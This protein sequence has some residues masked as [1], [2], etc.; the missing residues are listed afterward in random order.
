MKRI[1]PQLVS[2]S[3][4]LGS[5]LIASPALA[6][7][8]G[9]DPVYKKSMTGKPTVGLRIRDIACMEGSKILTVV[10]AG[11]PVNIV[12]E[13]DGWYKV[14]WNGHV[15]WMGAS[16]MSVTNGSAATAEKKA[17]T[18]E[19]VTL[20]KSLLGIAEKDFSL[21]QKKN[22]AL[23]DRLK[24]KVLLRVQ[25]GGETWYVE[26]DGTLSQVKMIKKGEFKRLK[27]AA[28]DVKKELK[29]EVK[30]EVKKEEKKELALGEA[31]TISLKGE[32]LPG[33]VKLT[34]VISGDGSKGFK[35]VKSTEANPEYPGDSAEYVDG[36]T[37]TIT[38]YGLSAKTYHF[39]VCRYTGNGCDVYSNNIELTIPASEKDT[40]SKYQSSNGELKLEA[41]VLP[42][43]VALSWTK[44]TSEKFEG[45][46]VVRSSS[47]ADPSYPA[48]GYV[49]YLPERDSLA[50]IDG[51]AI[52]GKYYYYRI[53]ALESG[54][55]A[56]C[57][58][59][60]KVLA[61]QR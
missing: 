30:K 46:K 40:S 58:N 31:G 59:V 47:N 41:A 11:T 9:A 44:R 60:V 33:G 10:P 8:C 38:R 29:E 1:L 61:K 19:E 13:T 28:K 50:F 53:C 52:P 57:G 36:N 25:K 42:G 7:D 16:L 49:E 26:K 43:A 45:Y 34:W 18:T 22:K 27:D 15:G 56:A 55:P 37:R 17:V 20:K 39:R 2:T 14:E 3:F 6:G 23:T 5:L 12:A 24:D 48:D 51:T 4:L 54:S 32:A 35:V 21:V